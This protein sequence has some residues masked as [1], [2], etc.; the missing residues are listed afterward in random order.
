MRAMLCMPCCACHAVRVSCRHMLVPQRKQTSCEKLQQESLME[1]CMT[2]YSLRW[3]QESVIT[4][5]SKMKWSSTDLVLFVLQ[6]E[7]HQGQHAGTQSRSCVQSQSLR[8]SHWLLQ[9]QQSRLWCACLVQVFL[10][11]TVGRGMPASPCRL[12]SSSCWD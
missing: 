8:D 11:D 2:Y 7:L 3:G 1:K 5:K 9:V 6:L 10:A 12:R 4:D